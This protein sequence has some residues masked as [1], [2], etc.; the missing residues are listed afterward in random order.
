[1]SK[2]IDTLLFVVRFVFLNPYYKKFS[3]YY[4]LL[5]FY[6]NCIL[7]SAAN[8]VEIGAPYGETSENCEWQ[9]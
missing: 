5:Y 8:K 2:H 1:M 4:I 6:S 7:S 3:V 9:R